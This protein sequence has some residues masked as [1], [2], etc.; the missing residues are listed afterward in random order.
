MVKIY[1]YVAD[2]TGCGYYRAI[3]PAEQ[4]ARQTD[5]EVRIIGPNDNREISAE[6]DQRTGRVVA[7]NTPDCDVMV[8][9]RVTHKYL[10]QAIPF[11]RENGIAVVIDMDDDLSSIHPHNPAW[12]GLH[13][14]NGLDHNWRH[15]VEACE[16]ATLV[17][18]S[19]TALL[20]RYARRGHGVVLRNCVPQ[21][22]LDVKHEDSDLIGWGGSLHSHPDDVSQL[23]SSISQLVDD[24]HRF[25]TV[26]DPRGVAATL[27]LGDRMISLGIAPLDEWP[28]ML[29]KFGVGLAPSAP[30]EFNTAKSWLK[31][32][33]MAAVGVPCVISPRDEYVRLHQQCGVGLIAKK[34][35]DWYRL[36]KQ[37]VTT[38]S[39]RQ[40]LSIAQREGV[41][42]QTYEIR[43][44]YWAYA[45]EL[46]R[47]ME[48]NDIQAV[49]DADR[50]HTVA[51]R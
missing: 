23:G 3:W 35:R 39:M 18:V 31:P 27:R 42:R 7:V 40:E 12:V 34:Q 16:A 46:A 51:L 24:G 29:T 48:D 32:L 47:L 14:K 38:P 50:A 19:T 37:L 25:A 13:P 8:L 43:A 17:T 10:A 22:Y 6:I 45:W 36:I 28:T 30:S 41:S 1:V 2:L 20:R 26:G 49:S 33:E 21:R 44:Q 15:A 5:H 9:Q 4:V 11:I